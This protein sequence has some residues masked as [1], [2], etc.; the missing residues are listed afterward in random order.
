MMNYRRK[1]HSDGLSKDDN[2]LRKDLIRSVIHSR[3]S[4]VEIQTT[5][6]DLSFY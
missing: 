1:K 4:S 5:Y 2:Q 3:E 6:Q